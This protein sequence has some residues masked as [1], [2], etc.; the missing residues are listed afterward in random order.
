MRRKVKVLDKPQIFCP[1][2][3]EN[4]PEEASWRVL[5][6]AKRAEGS[7]WNLRSFFVAVER[8][9]RSLFA[10]ASNTS[11]CTSK[12]VESARRKKPEVR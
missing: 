3:S 11:T 8:S 4:L 1:S 9:L 12:T 10:V 7:S 6:R 2:E 5:S